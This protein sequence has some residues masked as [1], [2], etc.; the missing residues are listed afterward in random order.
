M[1]IPSQTIL[2]KFYTALRAL[3]T[4]SVCLQQVFKSPHSSALILIYHH[5]LRPV[6]D[7]LDKVPAPYCKHS[8]ISLPK[9]PAI[10]IYIKTDPLH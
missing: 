4:P 3:P 1:K 7:S 10:H 9:L 5:L 6:N 2:I 8:F